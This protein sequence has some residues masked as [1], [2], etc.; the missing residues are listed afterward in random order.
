[1][2]NK[3][4]KNYQLAAKEYVSKQTFPSTLATKVCMLHIDDTTLHIGD[5]PP[6]PQANVPL[7]CYIRILGPTCPGGTHRRAN[8][9]VVCYVLLGTLGP[10]C[11]R[12][13]VCTVGP[14]CPSRAMCTSRFQHTC[15]RANVPIVCSETTWASVLLWHR[16]AN[17]PHGAKRFPGN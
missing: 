3:I 1:M 11:P 17:V 4:P 15:G 16:M 5:I 9:P 8:V 14:K 13:D 6:H 2:R 12:S 10:M 7:A